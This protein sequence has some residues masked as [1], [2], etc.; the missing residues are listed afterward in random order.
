MFPYYK[1]LILYNFPKNQLRETKKCQMKKKKSRQESKVS[2]KNN[3]GT[4]SLV[5]WLQN[6]YE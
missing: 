2:K 6:I 1:R 3:K 5:T 4:Q